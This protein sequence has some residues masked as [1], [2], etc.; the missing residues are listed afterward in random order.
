MSSTS[1]INF[2]LVGAAKAGTTTV[3]ERLNNRSD[4]YLS[5][6]KE[7]NFYSDDIDISKFS[8]EFLTNTRLDLSGYFN[9]TP[10]PIRQIGFV[11]SAQEYSQLFDPAPSEA[12]LI[13]ECS[14]SYLWSKSAPVNIAKAHPKARILIMLRDP[15]S[16]LY[17][18]YMMARKYGFTSLP[19]IEAVQNDMNHQQKG[20]G[21][22]ELF[23]ELGMY[24]DQIC[25]YKNH[26]PESQIKIMLTSDL[27]NPN[28][29][30]G[31]ISWL[32]IS[33]DKAPLDIKDKTQDVNIAGLPRFES[34][35]R[36]LTKVGLKQK[37][38]NLIPSL[39]KT[40][41]ARWYYD[42]TSLPKMSEEESSF[43]K[44]IYSE[45]LKTLKSK[46]GISF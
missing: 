4:V 3:F 15:I 28:C 34:L 27:R 23:V 16:R 24:S 10:L 44:E 21:S 37:L 6:L 39:I 8:T 14:T 42:S 26:F 41:L 20:W 40:P 36:I 13:G 46:H 9:Q 22:S 45:E 18:H 25:R 12:K 38:G 29:W 11:R 7:P 2:F 32:G 1:R 19:L 43:L 35:N 5:P 17:S 30:S 33:K 31:L